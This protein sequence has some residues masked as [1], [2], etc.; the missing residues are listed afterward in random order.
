LKQKTISLLK[1]NLNE[2]SFGLKY[3]NYKN[4]VI[5]QLQKIDTKKE[6]LKHIDDIYEPYIKKAYSKNITSENC[7]EYIKNHWYKD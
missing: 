4:N 3:K 1:E 5:K 6:S 2:A 7:A